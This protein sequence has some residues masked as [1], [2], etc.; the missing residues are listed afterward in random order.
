M[1]LNERDSRNERALDVALKMM[2]AARTAPKGRGL[3]A[4]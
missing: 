2:T 1:V 4:V 3:D